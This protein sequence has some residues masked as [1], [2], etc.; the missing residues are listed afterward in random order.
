MHK[1]PH[2]KLHREQSCIQR[3]EFKS[4]VL[5]RSTEVLIFNTPV[6]VNGRP[7]YAHLPAG[8]RSGRSDFKLKT[9]E[10]Q[11]GWHISLSQGA[12]GS[13]CGVTERE[14][15]CLVPSQVKAAERANSVTMKSTVGN[16]LVF[17]FISSTHYLENFVLP[18]YVCLEEN[19]VPWNWLFQYL[20]WWTAIWF[21]LVLLQ[22][23]W[24][25]GHANNLR[26]TQYSL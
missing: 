7:Q 14:M 22:W 23:K 13:W 2:S 11:H 12:R 9:V 20:R 10:L 18:N 17:H 6:N 1:K 21:P 24:T 5:D 26:W 25:W 16:L 3:A 19:T 15:F 8:T 4:S